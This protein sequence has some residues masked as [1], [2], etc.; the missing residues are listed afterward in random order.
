MRTNS[1]VFVAGLI[2]VLILFY[3]AN[4]SEGTWQ[5]LLARADSLYEV[6]AT[7]SALDLGQRSLFEIKQKWGTNDTIYARVLGRYARYMTRIARYAEA[8]SL[9]A[10]AVRTAESI[11]GSEHLDV[12]RLLEYRAYTLY[13][14]GNYPE[15]ETYAKRA[16]AIFRKNLGSEDPSIAAC[17]LDLARVLYDKSQLFIA[18]AYIDSAIN[19]YDKVPDSLEYE[20]AMCLDFKARI[21][22]MPEDAV[23]YCLKAIKIVEQS[24]GECPA[25]L[26][27]LTNLADIYVDLNNDSGAQ[28]ATDR[29]F[30]IIK[31]YHM[32]NSPAQVQLLWAQ[33]TLYNRNGQFGKSVEL[34]E[35]AL[36]VCGK[37]WG[38]DYPLVGVLRYSIAYKYIVAGDFDKAIAL[39]KSALEIIRKSLNPWS[40][41]AS[42]CELMLG[43]LLAVSGDFKE[44][45]RYYREYLESSRIFARYIFSNATDQYKMEWSQYRPFI[46]GS[47]ITMA[48]QS[49]DDSLIQASSE[50][51]LRGKAVVIDAMMAEREI[52]VCS[53]DKEIYEELKRH[54]DIG[55]Q[56]GRIFLSSLGKSS[57]LRKGDDSLEIL[58]EEQSRLEKDLGRRCAEFQEKLAARD[59]KLAD[60]SRAIPEGTLLIE[61][62]SYNPYNFKAVGFDSANPDSDRYAAITLDHNGQTAIYDL[63]SLLEINH[64]IDSDLTMIDSASADIFSSKI[65]VSERKINGISSRLYNLLLGP[66]LKKAVGTKDLYISPDGVLNLYPFECLIL[67]DNR[68]AIEE[69]RISYLASGRDLVRQQ[70]TVVQPQG[71]VIVA[72]PDFDNT[73][74]PNDSIPGKPTPRSNWPESPFRGVNNCL[75]YRFGNLPSTREEALA[76]AATFK[77]VGRK[78]ISEYY[79]RNAS[80]ET[81]RNLSGPPEVLHI[82]THGYYCNPEDSQG[83]NTIWNPLLWS[84]LALAGANKAMAYDSA[85]KKPADNGIMTALELSGLNLLG[86]NLAVMSACETGVGMPVNGE[87]VFGLRRALQHAGVRTI[88]MSMWKVPDKETSVLMQKFYSGWLGGKSKID[89]LRD[90]ELELLKVARAKYGSGHPL[91]WAGFIMAGNPN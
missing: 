67:P 84:G 85:E 11:L 22:E 91:L 31:K 79:G 77:S 23:I 65:A 32:E 21:I 64:L 89:A 12:G 27:M 5:S 51:T 50:M 49:K 72:D 36:R 76:V 48:L 3:P 68:Y 57:L 1:E 71:V 90:A 17:M 9:T 58:F 14:L 87:G 60:I 86:T 53:G 74:I 41:N 29:A 13:M 70:R 37:I 40:P 59:F 28:E 10:V 33:S 38:P 24:R 55:T 73:S 43:R 69:Y 25:L 20:R 52:A 66:I 42:M 15:S 63:G 39:D 2:I 81:L 26:F 8:D 62:L 80:K 83:N 16:M 18:E 61:Y 46:E 54:S 44:S 56:I 47:L 88:V 4:S 7:D 19:I 34:M 6:F 82:A 78:D 30:R 35:E 75:N 45:C